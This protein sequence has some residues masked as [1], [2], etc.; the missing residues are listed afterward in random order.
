MGWIDF[1]DRSAFMLIEALAEKKQ[2]L[3]GLA[4][5]TGLAPSTVHKKMS[6]MLGQEMVIAE[7]RKNAKFFAPNYASPLT[8]KTISLIFAAKIT[9]CRAFAKLKKM[10]P[11][12]IYVFGTAA[13]GKIAA[14]SDIDLAVLF[15]KKPDMIALGEIKMQMGNELGREVQVIAL[16]PEKVRSMEKEGAELLREIRCKSAV[17]WGAEF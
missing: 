1:L 15:E 10:K 14:D 6:A 2:H 3:R 5:A 12:G 16:T 11:L 13:S 7:K 17:L 4:E 8:A 9:N